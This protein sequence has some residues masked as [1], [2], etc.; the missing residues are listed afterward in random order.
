MKPEELPVG[1]P[2]EH[3]EPIV[4]NLETQLEDRP[5]L[6]AL[7]AE[8]IGEYHKTTE[9]EIKVQISREPLPSE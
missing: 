8:P 4:N 9:E 6:K 7:L 1:F 3:L 5:D 2:V